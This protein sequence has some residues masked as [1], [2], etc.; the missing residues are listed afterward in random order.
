MNIDY[1]EALK[2]LYNC[3]I[4]SDVDLLPMDDRNTYTCSNQPRHLS[5]S[6]DKFGFRCW[7]RLDCFVLCIHWPTALY[8][9][10]FY[11][12]SQQDYCKLYSTVLYCTLL[13]C[14]LFQL[15]FCVWLWCVC[16]RVCVCE[17]Q[18]L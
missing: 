10:L 18:L 4:F 12:N 5:V 9:S 2:D 13:Y 15:E 8:C 17:C 1:K 3:F 7:L 14:A 6:I 11:C 16:V